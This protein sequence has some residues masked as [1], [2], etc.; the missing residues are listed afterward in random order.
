MDQLVSL[1]VFGLS[2][3]LAANITYVI[4][5]SSMGQLVLFQALSCGETLVTNIAH[6]FYTM[7]QLLLSQKSSEGKS[8]AANITHI[9]F[10]SC[11]DQLVFVQLTLYSKSLV[12]NNA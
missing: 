5:Y 9:I 4:L 7:E 2:K 8:L 11:M 6:I 3:C 1:Q 10:L 12:A